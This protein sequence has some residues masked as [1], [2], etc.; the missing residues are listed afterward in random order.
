M[1]GLTMS[2]I[3]IQVTLPATVPLLPAPALD[4]AHPNNQPLPSPPAALQLTTLLGRAPSEHMQTLYSLYASQIATIIWT[5]ESEGP[6]QAS[7]RSVV[8]GLALH[9]SDRTS[10]MGV[11]EHERDTFREVMTML[12]ELLHNE[13]PITSL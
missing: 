5:L 9:K 8:V 2:E 13:V 7:R 6:L 3:K 11:T 4:P 1:D 12:Y 10:D